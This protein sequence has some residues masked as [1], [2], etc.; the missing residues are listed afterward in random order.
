VVDGLEDHADVE[1]PFKV[2]GIATSTL[3]EAS[4]RPSHCRAGARL[5]QWHAYTD[6]AQV[7]WRVPAV[8]SGTPNKVLDS[9]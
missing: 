9:N 2:Y 7:V 5:L 8:L 4:T 1:P 6:I 3:G